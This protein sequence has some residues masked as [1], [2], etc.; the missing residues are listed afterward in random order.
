MDSESLGKNKKKKRKIKKIILEI[1]IYLKE[2][3]KTKTAEKEV[4][5]D[6]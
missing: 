5:D 1:N 6:R 4:R 2:M 3:K